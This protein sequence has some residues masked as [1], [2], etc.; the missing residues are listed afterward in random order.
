[1]RVLARISYDGS[2]FYGFQRL[3]NK[4]GVQNELERVLSTIANQSIV[5]HGAGR[6]DAG[7]H[8]LDQCVHFDFSKDVTLDKLKYVMNRLLSSAVSVR[9]LQ[10][11]DDNFHARYMVKNKTYVYQIYIGDKSAF[12]EDY[13]YCFSQKIDIN[14]MKTASKLFVGVHDFRNFV[15]GKRDDYFSIIH[16]IRIFKRKNMIYCE[17]KG[18]SFYRYMIRN[19]VGALICVGIGK[20]TLEEIRN[21]LDNSLKKKDFFVAPP[22]GLYLKN[23]KY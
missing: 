17:F 21:A 1:M 11:V 9:S 5:V 12:L 6:T 8:A 20:N 23:I 16:S 13:A 18:K 7:V 15:S 22:N 3:S 10:K 14:L 19:I 2:K 4:K